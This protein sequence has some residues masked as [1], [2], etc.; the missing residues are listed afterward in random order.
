MDSDEQF[1]LLARRDTEINDLARRGRRRTL[2]IMV[3]AFV[4][5]PFLV[6]WTNDDS[7]FA[8][9]IPIALA[10]FGGLTYSWA[11]WARRPEDAQSVA[12][13][14]LD[15]R[16]RGATYR[17]VWRGDPITDPVVLTIIESI[18]RHLR[19][20]VWGVVAAVV[21]IAGM[22]VALIQMAGPHPTTGI[23]SAIIGVVAA[24]F[25]AMHRVLMSRI[26]VSVLRS[27]SP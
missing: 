17:S 6:M 11:K 10:C 18:D 26:R 7:S 15:R 20:S 14:G 5:S 4:P 24:S 2:A 22:T 21:A 9:L 25:I 1:R 16:Q 8:S 13:V 23:A 27:P 3:L 19:Q 12:F